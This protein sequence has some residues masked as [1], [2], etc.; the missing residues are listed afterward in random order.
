MPIWYGFTTGIFPLA[1]KMEPRAPRPDLRFAALRKLRQAGI[2]AGVLCSP[3]LPGINDSLRS[4]DAV[5]SRAAGN[6]FRVPCRLA[7][8]QRSDR[9]R[10]DDKEVADGTITY[11][12]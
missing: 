10:N 12:L 5:A 4:L 7:I 11:Q 3:L 1:R 2:T 9:Q 6:L 8:R